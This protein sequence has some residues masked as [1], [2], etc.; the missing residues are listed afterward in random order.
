MIRSVATVMATQALSYAFPFI[1]ILFVSRLL[2]SDK[3]AALLYFQL[4]AAMLGALV[5]YGFHLSAVRGFVEALRCGSERAFISQVHF[6]KGLL[7]VVA[8]ALGAA[9]MANSDLFVW[10]VSLFVGL[11]FGIGFSGYRPMWYHQARGSYNV[12]LL[13]DC[14][15]NALSLV[16]LVAAA[17]AE[18]SLEWLLL[19]WATPRAAATLALLVQIHRQ[20]GLEAPSLASVRH[21]LQS[22]FLLFIQKV[23]ATG[24]L[25]GVPVLM[26]YLVSPTSLLSFL[27]AERILTATQSLL[28]PIGH[29][30]YPKILQQM[31]AP[32]NQRKLAIS[33]A[34][35]Q[36]GAASIS[37]VIIY[38]AAPF[39]LSLFWGTQAAEA[40]EALRWMC[41]TLPLTA[42]TVALGLNFLLPAHHDSTVASATLLGATASLAMLLA[43]APDMAHLSGVFAIVFGQALV[44]LLLSSALLRVSNRPG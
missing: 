5:E 20:H 16:L 33:T 37:G 43:L 3:L 21:L 35:L 41:L 26:G 36:I 1:T 31:E 8:A 42:L 34:A 11:V 19:A 44:A 10:H 27:Q 9:L 32:E 12:L 17:L 39:L 6:A 24:I 14:V 18:F 13:A 2:P 15:G 4:M 25:L 29:V 7:L 30:A 38:F 23:G 22:S 28:L 40:L